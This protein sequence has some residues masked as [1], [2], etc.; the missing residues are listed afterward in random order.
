MG[1]KNKD[2]SAAIGSRMDSRA[3]PLPAGSVAIPKTL[4]L[5]KNN[6]NIRL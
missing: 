1:L 6:N 3:A 4:I 2:V 5:N